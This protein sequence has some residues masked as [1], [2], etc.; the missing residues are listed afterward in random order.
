MIHYGNLPFLIIHHTR[1]EVVFHLSI[2]REETP[3]PEKRLTGKD[4]QNR[5]MAVDLPKIQM[6]GEVASHPSFKCKG[7]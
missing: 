1:Q 4:H 3:N 5:Y 7:I 2:K 6:G